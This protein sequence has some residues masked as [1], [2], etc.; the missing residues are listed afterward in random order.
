MSAAKTPNLHPPKAEHHAHVVQFYTDDRFLLDELSHFIGAALAAG[1]SAVVIATKGHE[2]NLSE[3]LT[4]QGVD[5]AK[6]VADGRYVVLD[7]AET[8]AR[9]MVGGL[10]DALRFA[11]ILGG[12]IARAASAA[13]DENHRVVAFGEMVAPL[14]AEGKAEAALRTEKLWN[15]LARATRFRCGAR[16]PCRDSAGKNTPTHCC[17]SVTNTRASFPTRVTASLRLKKNACAVWFVCNS[18]CR[19]C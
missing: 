11:E 4:S 1:N 5:L 3:R 19:C 18:R 8:L 15:Q 9:F 14:W 16:I 13:T 12:V 6:A 7:A 2:N 10:P 17:G